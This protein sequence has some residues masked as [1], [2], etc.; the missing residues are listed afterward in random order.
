VGLHFQHQVILGLNTVCFLCLS[1]KLH[2][3]SSRWSLSYRSLKFEPFT[4]W[5]SFEPF[6]C[7]SGFPLLSLPQDLEAFLAT[8]ASLVLVVPTPV[9]LAVLLFQDLGT[10][11]DKE[12][13]SVLQL[14]T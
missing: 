13:K 10:C 2:V 11:T 7:C 4:F 1:S 3:K 5:K 12:G 6:M 8:R 9:V 14:A